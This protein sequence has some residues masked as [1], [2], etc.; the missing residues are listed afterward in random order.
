MLSLR[1]SMEPSLIS[2][3]LVQTQQSEMYDRRDLYWEQTREFKILQRNLTFIPTIEGLVLIEAHHRNLIDKERA[4]EEESSFLFVKVEKM[5]TKA[6]TGFGNLELLRYAHKIGVPIDPEGHFHLSMYLKMDI[7]RY[8]WHEM[9]IPISWNQLSRDWETLEEI[10]ETYKM[11]IEGGIQRENRSFIYDCLVS[12]D[13]SY[14][15]WAIDKRIPINLNLVNVL[16]ARAAEGFNDADRLY[17]MFKHHQLFELTDELLAKAIENEYWFNR[18]LQDNC[19]I[20]EYT[21][22]GAIDK[23]SPEIARMVMSRHNVDNFNLQFGGYKNTLEKLSLMPNDVVDFAF[24]KCTDISIID[25]QYQIYY[26]RHKIVMYAVKY[27]YPLDSKMYCN[28]VCVSGAA[29]LELLYGLGCP[30]DE[31]TMLYAMSSC[32]P[33]AVEFLIRNDCPWNN[34]ACEFVGGRIRCARHPEHVCLDPIRMQTLLHTSGRHLFTGKI[35]CTNMCQYCVSTDNASTANACV[36]CRNRDGIMRQ[37]KSCAAFKRV[38]CNKNP[39]CSRIIKEKFEEC[40]NCDWRG[41]CM[42]GHKRGHQH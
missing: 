5:I 40:H 29:M 1:H 37:T 28:A 32:N 36:E 3:A 39:D 42:C 41:S 6:L 14:I 21:F 22:F 35:R 17:D 26:D 20:G 9:G 23:Q 12:H 34:M 25:M 16:E 10:D 38:T 11:I 19:K 27:G 13:F 18:L 8:L 2:V 31:L 30:F 24:S 33:E 7:L 4:K 15:Q